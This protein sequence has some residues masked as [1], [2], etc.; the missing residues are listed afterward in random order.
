MTRQRKVPTLFSRALSG[1]VRR[2]RLYES[3]QGF[4]VQEPEH[5]MRH[6]YS[7]ETLQFLD[8]FGAAAGHEVLLRAAYHF[9]GGF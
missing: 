2:N 7:L 8:H 5:E 4:R 6:P 1:E 9:I 3:L